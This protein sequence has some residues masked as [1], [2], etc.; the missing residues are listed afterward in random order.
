MHIYVYLNYFAVQQKLTNIVNQLRLQLKIHV[1]YT[2]EFSYVSYV[3]LFSN[4]PTF[5]H[6]MWEQ[7]ETA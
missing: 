2:H 6:A 3:I 5:M 1:S 7:R 4:Y